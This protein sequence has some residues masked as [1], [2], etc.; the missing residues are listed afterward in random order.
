[1]TQKQNSPRPEL[2][3]SVRREFEHILGTK[4]ISTDPATLSGYAWN[5]GVG[6]VPGDKKFADIWPIAV[7]LPSTTEEV[8]AVIKCCLRNGLHYRAHSTGYGSMACVPAL[9]CV[10]IDLRRMNRLL[11]FNDFGDLV[12][13][14]QRHTNEARYTYALTTE[15]HLSNI[16]VVVRSPRS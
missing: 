3:A 8:A 1:M 2:P 4:Y 14:G 12:G 5:T 15:T 9:D 16:T 11:G 13:L 7:V 10:S 6:K